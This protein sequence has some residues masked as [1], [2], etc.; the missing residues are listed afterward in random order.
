[1]DAKS[2]FSA[3]KLREAVSQALDGV[4]QSPLDVNGRFFLAELLCF[5]GDWE[6]AEKQLEAVVKQNHEA[7]LLALLARQLIRGEIQREQVFAEARPPQLVGE[8]PQHAVLQLELCAAVRSENLQ[9]VMRLVVHSE[10]S[11]PRTSG[12]FNGNPV[13]D[14]RDLDDRIAGVLEVITSTGKYY[15]VPWESVKSLEFSPP[16]RPLDLIW[17]KALIDVESGPEGEV[18]IPTRYPLIPAMKGQEWDDALKLGR[19]SDWPETFGAVIGMG[20]RMFLVGEDS[21]SMLEFKT[22]SRQLAPA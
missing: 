22:W 12:T 16:E 17:R 3:G 19:A 15:W 8:L 18:F 11:R 4:K 5:L 6:K 7:G 10:E 14:L 13:S 9:E 21:T 2:L 1:M 20:Q